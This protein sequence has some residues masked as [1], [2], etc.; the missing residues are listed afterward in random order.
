MSDTSLRDLALQVAYEGTVSQPPQRERSSMSILFLSCHAGEGKSFVARQVYKTL[1]E[2]KSKRAVL[3]DANFS[4]PAHPAAA[5]ATNE[6]SVA[7]WLRA[8]CVN[9]DWL[10]ATAGVSNLYIPAGHNASTSDFF[11]RQAWER[12][13]ADLRPCF[14]YVLIDGPNI[15]EGAAALAT[16][17]SNNILIIDA[18]ATKRKTVQLHLRDF[19]IL[20]TKSLGIFL[21]KTQNH[22]PGFISKV[23]PA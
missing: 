7:G 15:R 11:N 13:L 18:S 6:V 5:H 9:P 10:A 8:Q 20:K 2:M 3:L 4:R 22:V 19:P 1:S 12:I 23:L 16:C 14:D 21:N 17:C